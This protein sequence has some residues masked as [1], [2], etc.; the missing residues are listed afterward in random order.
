MSDFYSRL[1]DVLSYCDKKC[2]DAARLISQNCSD[3]SSLA[4]TDASVISAL[5]GEKYS[6]MIRVL[7]G[8]AARR[9]TDKFKFGRAHS[10]E[11]LFEFLS[12]Y[13]LD[14]V[15]ETVLLLP[16]DKRN[17]VISAEVIVEGTVNF[18]GVLTRKILEIMIKYNSESA[19]LVHNHPAGKAVASSEDIETTRIVA[20]LL[21]SAD[22]HLVCHYIVSGN[23]IA[24]I[25]ADEKD[26]K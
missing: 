19:I 1:F 9:I 15:N 16:L 2:E 4:Q 26:K 10:E 3:F 6:A 11:E 12:G 22:K 8:I 21:R 25:E 18:S 7:S 17:R 23:E 14:V 13:Y 24:K 20:E 5:S